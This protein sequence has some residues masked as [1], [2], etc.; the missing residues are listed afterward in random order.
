M[1]RVLPV[2]LLLLAG[3]V[4][5]SFGPFCT[6]KSVVY[7]REVIGEWTLQKDFGDDVSTNAIRAWVFSGDT[8]TNCTLKAFDKENVGATFAVRFFRLGKNT[9]VDVMPKEPGDET[10]INSYWMWTVRSTHTVCKVELNNDTLTLKALDYDWLKKNREK[11]KRSLPYMET[12]EQDDSI[13]F[14][15]SPRQWEA[16]LS[17]HAS[18]EEV[19]PEEHAFVLKRSSVTKP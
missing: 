14:T 17:K 9:F 4:V 11:R 18:N 6:D 10:K 8:G 2:C 19:F 3:C 16:S 13:L 7:V 12:T 5:Q 1:K 15:A